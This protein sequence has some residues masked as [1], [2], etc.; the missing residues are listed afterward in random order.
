MRQE[1]PAA[2]AGRW[3]AR[4]V[5]AIST[6]QQ[7][8]RSKLALQLQRTALTEFEPP[9]NV[10]RRGALLYGKGSQARRNSHA[11]PAST[12]AAHP[13]Q[14][15]TTFQSQTDA[16]QAVRWTRVGDGSKRDWEGSFSF[17]KAD[18]PTETVTTDWGVFPDVV[19]PF[20]NFGAE[21]CFAQG[22]TTIVDARTHLPNGK[23]AWSLDKHGFCYVSR[24][25]YDFEE[26]EEQD[27]RRVN[28]EFAPKVLET[29]RL[30]AG[31][32]KAFWLSHMRRGEPS[33]RK[34]GIVADG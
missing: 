33:V 8:H 21:R 7:Q 34:V 28:K 16:M 29:V 23:E 25:E 9:D 1:A 26:H 20:G 3:R 14:N 12:E 10:A 18:A 13:G 27:F 4:F 30:A 6:M 19:V 17:F 11:A 2:W 22:K 5:S 31:A 15:D 32:Q 24:P